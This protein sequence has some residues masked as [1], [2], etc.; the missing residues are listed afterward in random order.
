[1]IFHLNGRCR[2]KWVARTALDKCR[3]NT[4]TDLLATLQRS[5]QQPSSPAAAS[6][7]FPQSTLLGEG[8]L[9]AEYTA[10]LE[11]Q[12]RREL[13][14]KCNSS[15]SRLSKF[16]FSS[17]SPDDGAKGQASRKYQTTLDFMLPG[18]SKPSN[19][20]GSWVK[21]KSSVPLPRRDINFSTSSSS[22]QVKLNWHRLEQQHKNWWHLQRRD[23]GDDLE[24]LRWTCT[25]CAASNLVINYCENCKAKRSSRSLSFSSSSTAAMKTPVAVELK[26]RLQ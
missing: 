15:S 7:T 16:L 5:T 25:K 6:S 1:M 23:V 14:F 18:K 21:V 19:V 17:P 12:K 10:A 20:E 11:T 4:P 24:T 22:A 26:G 13:Q 2:R 3:Q 9:R 8:V